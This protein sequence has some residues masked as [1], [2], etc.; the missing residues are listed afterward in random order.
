MNYVD[1]FV[2]AVPTAN[3]HLYIDHVTEVASMFKKH[4]ALNYV[5]CWGDDVPPGEITSF[6][7]AVK[8]QKE[9][10]VVFSWI[11]W[12]SKAARDSGM[13][14]VMAEYEQLRESNPMPFDAKRIIYGG[15][16]VIVDA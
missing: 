7:D 15:F 6:P 12:S 8:L 4:G 14:A 10:T 1:G 5:E 2:A 9:E 11:T 13:K 3:K 16:E